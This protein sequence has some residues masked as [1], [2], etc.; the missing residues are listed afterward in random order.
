MSNLGLFVFL[1][2]FFIAIPFFVFVKLR[3]TEHKQQTQNDLFE[4]KRF[5]SE[6]LAETSQAGNENDPTHLAQK[7][8][9]SED[10]EREGSGGNEKVKKKKRAKKKNTSHLEQDGGGGEDM[11]EKGNSGPQIKADVVC[12]YPFTSSTSATQ[13]KI[14]KQYDE[15]MKCNASK[16]LTLSQVGQFATCLV[17]ARNELQHKADAIQRKFT[18]RKA[19]LYKA[20]R[21]SFDRLRKQICKLE[22]EQKRLEEDA[23]VYNWLQ[24]QLKLSPAYKKM[25]EISACTELKTKSREQMESKDVDFTGISFEDFLAQEKKDSFWQKNMKSRSCSS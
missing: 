6:T 12:F 8:S 14:K 10:E 9:G 23:S 21:S 2:T 5:L 4:L 19:L 7:G 20:D 11:S 22:L 18:I 25:L 1:F 3:K 17:E 16:K 15:L 24:Q 13:R